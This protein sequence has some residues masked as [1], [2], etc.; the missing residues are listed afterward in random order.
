MP[1]TVDVRTRNN[2]VV[3]L[4]DGDLERL[5]TWQ[6]GRIKIGNWVIWGAAAGSLLVLG[7]TI[8]RYV[9]D[10]SFSMQEVE[11]TRNIL[12]PTYLT[13]VIGALLPWSRALVQSSRISRLRRQLAE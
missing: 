6:N 12:V 8:Y 3:R 10:A 11:T 4:T 2:Q 9:Q 5:E 7:E 13:V 1:A